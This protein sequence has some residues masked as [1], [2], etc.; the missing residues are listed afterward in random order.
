[1]TTD[2][3]PRAAA[4]RDELPEG[5]TCTKVSFETAEDARKEIAWIKA[6]EHKFGALHKK[7]S[8]N[9]H[10]YLCPHCGKYHLT[11]Q[12]AVKYLG[13]RRLVKRGHS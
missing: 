5:N 12:K 4:L 8:K 3:Q 9:L 7:S 13:R 6:G 1:M 11:S 10:V 2:Y